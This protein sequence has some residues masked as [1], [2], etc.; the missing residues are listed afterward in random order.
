M[1]TAM[2]PTPMRP[3]LT[4][5]AL[6]ES[7]MA[8]NTPSSLSSMAVLLAMTKSR[9]ILTTGQTEV[10]RTI[11]T[12]TDRQ[13]DTGQPAASGV[14]VAGAAPVTAQPAD[15]DDPTVTGIAYNLQQPEVA[16]RESCHTKPDVSDD[17]N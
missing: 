4:V 1:A 14:R 12:T 5:L 6:G 10:R 13:T 8:Q 16:A 11:L 17:A 7:H 3:P 15:T 9:T 2:A